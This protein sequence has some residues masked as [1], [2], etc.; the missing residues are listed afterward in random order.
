[1]KILL[2]VTM[3]MIVA[4]NALAQMPKSVKK[5][6]NKGTLVV[7]YVCRFHKVE[8]QNKEGKQDAIAQR[9]EK[10]R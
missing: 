3:L 1:M 10:H 6:E 9:K 4:H 2:I 7:E 8:P 5:H